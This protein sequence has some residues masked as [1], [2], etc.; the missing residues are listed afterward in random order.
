M[1]LDSKRFLDL[2]LIV[3]FALLI[4]AA[5]WHCLTYYTRVMGGICY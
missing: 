5:V 4:G 3:G 2:V 1:K